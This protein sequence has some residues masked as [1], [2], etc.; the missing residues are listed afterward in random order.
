MRCNITNESNI[1]RIN[2]KGLNVILQIK[3]I[4][5]IVKLGLPHKKKETKLPWDKL[6]NNI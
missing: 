4:L 2:K 5:H 1:T 3:V 6:I